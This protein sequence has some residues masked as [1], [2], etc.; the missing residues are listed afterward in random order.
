MTPAVT[1]DPMPGPESVSLV[2]LTGAAGLLLVMALLLTGR[3]ALVRL[4][5][6]ASASLVGLT[7]YLRHPVG[8]LH[9]TL[10][11]WFLTPLVRRLVDWRVGFADH[12]L[13]LL[14]PLLVSA[15]AGLT[16]L[17][18]R[19]VARPLRLVPFFLCVAGILY[20]FAVGI[21]RWRL[22]GSGASSPGE[23]FYGMFDWIAPLLFGL[24]LYL[25]WPLYEEHRHALQKSFLWA[26]LILGVYGVYQCVFAPAW[27][28][29][30]LEHVMTDL[31]DEA[32]GRPEPFQIRV[33]STLN[34]P[35]VF[36]NIL[37]AGLLLLF[38]IKSR[39]KPLA[40]TAGYCAFLL[41]L[42]RASWL[43]WLIGLAVYVR[44]SKGRQVPRLMLSLVLLPVVVAPLMLNS[45]FANIV[46][47]RLQTF[48]SA[49]QDQSFQDRAEEYR[50]LLMRFAGD[51]FG[52]GLSNAEA[53]YGYVMD[54][55]I[56]QLLY[57]C[58]WV[59]SALFLTGIALCVLRMPSG[60][61][62]SDPVSPVYRAIV[63]AMLFEL[64]SGN[65]FIGPSG[66]LLWTCIGLG[67]SLQHREQVSAPSSEYPGPF[68]PEYQAASTFH[69]LAE[70]Q[71]IRAMTPHVE[72]E[73]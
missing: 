55:G 49:K 3:G 20:G 64:L 59:G 22:G 8:Y 45:Q 28:T 57:Y 29:L 33:W 40:T 10:W 9:F 2:W 61:G 70:A 35:G 25:S 17:R 73:S 12:N 69:S 42:V 13:V 56:L 66:L 36:G 60:R 72:P 62:S 48:Q 15:I 30:W 71:T 41:T 53:W 50:V 27:D 44:G 4:A 19:G 51:P 65:T 11:V 31:G 46:T 24:H 38:S 14:A 58:G 6:P 39:I 47:N 16:L 5:I 21:I 32:F 18:E 68:A 43:G 52:E 23:I 26:V 54:S 63:V 1:H 34:S 37:V 67:F 7:L